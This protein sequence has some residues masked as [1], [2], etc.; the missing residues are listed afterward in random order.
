MFFTI[1]IFVFRGSSQIN[2]HWTPKPLEK[3]MKKLFDPSSWHT[4][5][6]NRDSLTYLA[7]L[8]CPGKIL[9]T[10]P[11]RYLFALRVLKVPVN[12]KFSMFLMQ[13]FSNFWK[14]DWYLRIGIGWYWY[15]LAIYDFGMTGKTQKSLKKQK[16]FS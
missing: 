6:L 14:V 9:K 3:A 15:W 10:L 7:L 1:Y 5:M 13:K 2:D 12:H 8:H 16:N 11:N 4:L